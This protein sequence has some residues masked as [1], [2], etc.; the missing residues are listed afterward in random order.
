MTDQ[1]KE[2][3]NAY[4]REWNRKNPDKLKEYQA[5]YWQRKAENQTPDTRPTEDTNKKGVTRT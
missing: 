4:R 3:R 5:R 2:A 1:A